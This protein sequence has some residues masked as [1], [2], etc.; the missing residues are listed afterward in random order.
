MIYSGAV[1]TVTVYVV[2]GDDG[3][4][5]IYAIG[6]VRTTEEDGTTAG[7]QKVDPTPG[8][9]DGDGGDGDDGNGGN[10]GNGGPFDY[11][12]MI[13]T[14][15][16]AKVNGGTDA[17]DP[18]DWTL[19]VSKAVAGIFGDASM[20]FTYAMTITIPSD[21]KGVKNSYNAYIVEENTSGTGNDYVFSGT[22][23]NHGDID[24]ANSPIVF[25]P[26][27]SVTFRLRHGQHLVFIDTP[28]GTYYEITES[29]S[30]NYE[31]SVIVTYDTT[32]TASFKPETTPSE[33]KILAIPANLEKD[34]NLIKGLGTTKLFVGEGVNSAAFTNERDEITP[35][36]LNL[37]DLPFIGLIALAAG[38]LVVFIVM[39][40]RKGKN[41]DE[42]I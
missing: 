3:N 32:E 40:T 4:P 38:A 2:M 9:G 41:Y 25:T 34:G 30:P 21:I 16:Y 31:P 17:T 24:N 33:G 37:S 11:S 22:V 29:A 10:G 27:T 23:Y 5:E 1:Y 28:V 36:G 12:Q 18:D 8:G 26:G 20:Y 15:R 42:Q 7:S 39:K 6:A 19:S 14:N 35:T 13:F